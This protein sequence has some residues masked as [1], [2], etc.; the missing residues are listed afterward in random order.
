MSQLALGV[1]GGHRE[2]PGLSLSGCSL[3]LCHLVGA[4]TGAALQEGFEVQPT[5]VTPQAWGLWS[6]CPG[7]TDLMASTELLSISPVV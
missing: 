2:L 4:G 1:T 7:I 3:W 5:A 6:C